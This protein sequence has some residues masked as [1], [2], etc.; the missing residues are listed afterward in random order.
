MDITKV[1]RDT[2][3]DELLDL[4]YVTRESGPNQANDMDAVVLLLGEI[5]KGLEQVSQAIGYH[6]DAMTGKS[7]M[8]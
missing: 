4:W 5:A 6:A 8:Y 1:T 2:T 3:V 7:G